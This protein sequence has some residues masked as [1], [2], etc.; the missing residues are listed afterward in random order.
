[1]GG[2]GNQRYTGQGVKRREDLRFITGH[3]SYTA[4]ARPGK[5]L[6]LAF[7][8][9][10][11]A[12]ARVVALDAS[13]AAS[14]R[15]VVRVLA[16][17]DLAALGSPPMMFVPEG[18]RV[19][20][21]PILA[22]D[23][24]RY[25]GEP[26]AAV[27]ADDPYQAC[28]AA[29]VIVVDYEPLPVVDHSWEA[30][31]DVEALVHPQLDSNMAFV[32][33]RGSDDVGARLAEAE[34]RVDLR[35]VQSRLAAVPLEP[36]SILA[37]YE[38]ASGRLVVRLSTQMPHYDRRALAGMLGLPADRIRVI[39]PDVGGGFG[40]KGT[41][42][43]E[44][45]VVAYLAWT[46]R[47]A[48]SWVETRSESLQTMSQGRG[49]LAQVTLGL[50]NDGRIRALDVDVLS[51]MGAFLHPIAAGPPRNIAVM[52]PGP[53]MV[54]H[55]SSRVTAMF[56]NRAPIGPYRGA[57]RPEAAFLIERAMD[58]AA[59]ALGLDPAE[60]RRRNFIPAEAFPYRTVTGATYDS[61]DYAAAFER[62]L[63]LADYDGLRLEQR[64]AREQG[65][66]LGIGIASFVEPA[67][68]MLEEFAE[69]RVDAAGRVTLL[70]GSSPHG[71][72][73][74][75]TFAQIVADELQVPMEQVD[76][77]CGDTDPVADGIGTFG[78]RS[79]ML[80]GSAA[81]LACTRVRTAMRARA[82]ELLE[83]RQ[84]DVRLAEGRF[85]VV[86]DA[87]R[88]ISFVEVARSCHHRAAGA[89]GHP[90]AF[91]EEFAMERE[92]YPFGT[93]VCAVE[94]DTETGKVRLLRYVAVDDCGNVINP[95]LVQGQI[96]GGIAQGIGQALFEEVAYD[97]SGQLL[98]G[99][100][101]DYALPTA[102]DVP[103]PLLGH[104]VTVSPL[105]PLGAKGVG[106]A[107]TIAAPAAI[108]NAVLDALAP[109]GV[110][111]LDMPFTPS[112]VWLAIQTASRRG[113]GP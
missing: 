43:P 97:E 84:D 42:C 26:V 6:H 108:A 101:V 36:R 27:L 18:A 29:N 19:P 99:S 89:A 102:A 25:V 53:Y 39:A 2:S 82:A 61:G 70:S 76:V 77:V 37:R 22:R 54:P 15:G 78:S 52:C 34:R 33:Q 60:I 69:V 98:S 14:A 110:T 72:G 65:R 71:Q 11:Y 45:A 31:E 100:L 106:E 105:N 95:L 21:R 92:T 7:V 47:C 66:Y 109:L 113:A 20:Q 112:K 62:A 41:I 24:V 5:A 49:H 17:A 96:Q 63:R 80:G 13:L 40:A 28:D 103:Q 94:V 104:T 38:A 74:E 91:S 88:G 9:S 81:V 16:A 58:V 32:I 90:L 73:H 4:D 48:V 30:L 23:A 59:R 87:A 111:E 68:A 56:T 85:H 44:E 3:G 64:D 51:D 75:T 86:G 8:R 35:I 67:G 93:H 107:G 83:A 57:G 46:E 12:H 10:P 50:G 1:M 55:A 79:A